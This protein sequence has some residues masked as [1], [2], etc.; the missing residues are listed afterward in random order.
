[1]RNFRI[2][3]DGTPY[4]V[5][6]EELDASET[7]TAPAIPVPAPPRPVTPSN[8]N[9]ASTPP[10]AAPGASAGGGVVTSPLA[11]TVV[12][13]EVAL[14]QVVKQGQPV[15]VLEAMKMNTHVTASR[16]GTVTA[17]SIA[18]GATVSEGQVLLSIG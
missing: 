9:I 13:I 18:A 12:S 8:H 6:V 7:A 15:I 5:S 14:G 2:T 1:M 4:L 16:G 10:S 11:G 3:V 17:I